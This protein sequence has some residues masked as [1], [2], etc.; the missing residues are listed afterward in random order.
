MTPVA[1]TYL[2][3]GIVAFIWPLILLFRKRQVLGAQ[4]LMMLSMATVGVAIVLYSCLFNSFLHDEYLLVLLYMYI[5][6][7]TPP[8]MHVSVS[9]LTQPVGVSRRARAVFLPTF[10]MMLIMAASVI[11]GGSDMYLI[12]IQR[13]SIGEAGHI[14]AGSWRYDLIV[15]IHYYLY[16]FFLTVEVLWVAIFTIRRMLRLEKIYKEYYAV[17]HIVVATTRRLCTAIFILGLLITVSLTIF[18]FNSHRPLTFAVAT[19]AVEALLLL[20][21]GWDIYHLHFGAEQVEAL[22]HASALPRG[23]LMQLARRI[24][25]YV[26]VDRAYLN[27]DLSVFMLSERYHVSQ[28]EVVDAIHKM[29]GMSFGEYIDGQRI[30]HAIVV[31]QSLASL[32]LDDERERELLAHQ[33]GYLN[34]AAFERTFLQVMQQTVEQWYTANS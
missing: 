6:L 9:A 3:L 28:D 11:V 34:A 20:I 25:D 1:L 2:S 16:W 18:P 4:W 10:V 30:E 14:Y 21:I 29:H 7:L 31:M 32:H 8:M 23:D 26:E 15:A 33:C 13:G 22:P 24:A 17:P 19:A 5:S 27:P 12:W